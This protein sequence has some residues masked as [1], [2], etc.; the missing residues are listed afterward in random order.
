M[1]GV[2]GLTETGAGVLL[3]VGLLT[4]LAGAMILGVMLNAVFSAK[5]QKGLFGG[6]ELD[7]LYAVIGTAV[8]FVG[9]GAYSVDRVIG[10]HFSAWTMHGWPNGVGAIV[11][12]AV[13]GAITLATR[14]SQVP[15]AAAALSGEERKAA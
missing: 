6:Y 3:I 1:A 10:A 14:R 11:L 5:L 13:A 9:A 2:T 12:A 15:A 7:V 4:P 8:A